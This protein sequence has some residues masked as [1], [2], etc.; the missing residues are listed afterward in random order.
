MKK[1]RVCASCKGD[2]SKG[3]YMIA[4]TTSLA[5]FVCRDCFN[6]YYEELNKESV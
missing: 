6:A 5:E 3:V 2:M 1:Q 4:K